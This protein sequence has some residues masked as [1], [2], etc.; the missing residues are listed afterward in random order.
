MSKIFFTRF[1]LVCAAVFALSVSCMGAVSRNFAGGQYFLGLDGIVSFVPGISGGAI[2][3][4]LAYYATDP[5]SFKRKIISQ[6]NFEDFDIQVGF[7]RGLP[8][9]KWISD[10]FLPPNP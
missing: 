1:V 7:S 9:H 6:V 8:I 5:Y 4:D 2:S 3:A 10:T